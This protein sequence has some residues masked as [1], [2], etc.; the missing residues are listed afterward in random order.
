MTKI[1]TDFTNF[2]ASEPLEFITNGETNKEAEAEGK[3]IIDELKEIL[4][5]DE[6]LIALAAPQIGINKRIFCIKFNDIIKTFINPI[7]KKKAG[8]VIAPETCASMPGKEILIS[9]P[10]EVSVI[11][12]TEEFKYEDNK[13]LGAAARLF[14]QQYQLL[15]GVLPS[16]LGL[17]SDVEQDG[18]L[19]DLSEEE[20]AQ[21]TEIYKQ[22]IQAKMKALT[23]EIKQDADLEK[24]YKMLK[25][26]EDVVNGRATITESEAEA[27][28]RQEAKKIANKSIALSNKAIM[29]AKKAERQAQLNNFLRHK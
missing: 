3:K 27:K 25:F 2:E 11:Y 21:V 7:I 8:N 23:E 1:I 16:E 19:A 17:V 5:S 26:T 12:Y 15:D 24:S 29:D 18:S 14:D 9:R 6:S 20:I 28:A 13:L 22:F 10:E 4:N